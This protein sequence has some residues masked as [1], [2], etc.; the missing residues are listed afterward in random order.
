MAIKGVALTV[1]FTVWDTL[2]NTGKTGDAPQVSVY[3]VVNGALS[4]LATSTVTE[5]SS[6][7][8]PGIYKVSLSASE[9][10]YSTITVAGKSSTSGVVV[11]P[12]HIITEEGLVPA[13][14]QKTSALTFTNGDVKA[15]LDSEGVN[16]TGLA[17]AIISSG[18]FTAG[19]IN[20][21]VAPNLDTTIS[22]RLA[23]SNYSENGT[24]IE[25]YG[26]STSP[27]NI[28]T[29]TTPYNAGKAAN[30]YRRK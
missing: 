23:S 27:P 22:S 21:A 11:I 25:I 26:A 2:T 3:L 14:N 18:S 19:A 24:G 30:P 12:A 29:T 7:N 17:A 4:S 6:S 20:Q 9:T 16:V 10:N 1:P 28:L 13:I 15:T 8:C 5:V